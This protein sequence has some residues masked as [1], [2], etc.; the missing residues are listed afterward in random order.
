MKTAINTKIWDCVWFA[1]LSFLLIPVIWYPTGP[2]GDIFVLAGKAI[3]NGKIPYRDFLDI[4]PAAFYYLYGLCSAVFPMPMG[5]RLVE[6]LSIAITAIL[7]RK[8][9]TKATNLPAWGN[10]AGVVLVLLYSSAQYMNIG[11]PET[12]ITLPL[13]LQWY[14][15]QQ[16]FSIRNSIIIGILFGFM[17][18]MKYTFIVFGLYF[19]FQIDFSAR[20][21]KEITR[22]YTVGGVTALVIFALSN[23]SILF[24]WNE[25]LEIIQF[26]RA[27]SKLLSFSA[28]PKEL[29]YT[30]GQFF[31]QYS[32]LGIVGAALL[33]TVQTSRQTAIGKIFSQWLTLLLF[34]FLSIV[35]EYKFG[36]P[37]HYLRLILPLSVV[38]SLGLY[39]FYCKLEPLVTSKK[40]KSISSGFV[41]LVLL[42]V[43][44]PLVKLHKIFQPVYYYYSN[45]EKYAIIGD[46]LDK[47]EPIHITS[48]IVDAQQY[49]TFHY[50]EKVQV[51]VLS[52]VVSATVNRFFG[53]ENLYVLHGAFVMS[54]FTVPRWR[55]EY[56]KDLLSKDIVIVQ[57]NDGISVLNNH[58]LS[59]QQWLESQA[60]T[61]NIFRQKFTLVYQNN[62]FNIY[63]SIPQM[64]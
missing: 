28:L 46:P 54:S 30:T 14:Y 50:G 17:I 29:I 43:F 9:L 38:S 61:W 45:P 26:T 15:F 44:S 41:A 64:K 57:I 16:E 52:S 33:A 4:K 53:N 42:V 2:D 20:T 18:A 49:I 56:L 6:S 59:S 60:D 23:V 8:I 12:I 13:F 10:T 55:E 31:V 51:G 7:L 32:S 63:A 5:I 62:K 25:F 35:L 24:A 40:L 21:R 58:D 37:H 3:A 34:A 19:L 47:K 27:Y 1:I 11:I 22:F 48:D 36:Y 39:F